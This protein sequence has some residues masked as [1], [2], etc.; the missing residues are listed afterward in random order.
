M[1]FSQ[2]FT[3]HEMGVKRQERQDSQEGNKDV[4]VCDNLHNSLAVSA[5]LAFKSL[6]VSMEH[7]IKSRCSARMCE[8]FLKPWVDFRV[9][10]AVLAEQC[11]T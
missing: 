4:I 3:F 8:K 6:A 11:A 9:W 2:Q 1:H 5:F 7:P 10:E